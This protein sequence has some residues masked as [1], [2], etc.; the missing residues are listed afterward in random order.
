MSWGVSS[1]VESVSRMERVD[2][3]E[4]VDSE[5][6]S[7]SYCQGLGAVP[8]GTREAWVVQVGAEDAVVRP[9]ALS[10]GK[11]EGISK[12]STSEESGDTGRSGSER[13]VGRVRGAGVPVIASPPGCRAPWSLR[14]LTPESWRNDCRGSGVYEWVMSG[15]VWRPWPQWR[16]RYVVHRW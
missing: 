8:S 11:R 4:I 3:E 10:V 14:W 2:A 12:N 13:S 5:Q 15:L 9:S 16:C 7:E 1:V 6:T